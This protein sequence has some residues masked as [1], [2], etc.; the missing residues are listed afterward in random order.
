[1]KRICSV[2]LLIVI[3]VFSAPSAGF[4]ASVPSLDDAV[5]YHI[6]ENDYR[7]GDCVLTACNYMI[8][9]A[10]IMRKSHLWSTITN[11]KLRK[12][13]T[14][15]G[16]S[17]SVKNAYYFTHDGIR[18]T[19]GSGSLTGDNANEKKAVLAS[20]LNKYRYG[21]VVYGSNAASSGSHA[22][23]AVSMK[24]NTVYAADAAF[25]TG[26]EN[27][28]IQKWN[29]TIMKSISKCTK[30]WCI[31]EVSGGSDS[32]ESGNAKSTL[33]ISGIRAPEALKKGSGFSIKGI[34]ES[35]Y[36]LRTVTVMVK[37]KNG[38]TMISKQAKPEGWSYDLTRLDP[39]IKF[40]SLDNGTY[41]YIV[42]AEDAKK[43]KTLY[44][45]AFSVN[46]KAKSTLKIVSASVPGDK[47]EK[48]KAFS[49]KGIVKS[50]YRILSVKASITSSSDSSGKAL[51]K[52]SA[53]PESKS[54]NIN[55]FDSELKF[56]KLKKGKYVYKVSAKDDKKSKILIRKT[57]TVK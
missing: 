24:N 45:T 34:V 32:A 25:N 11:A 17:S 46:T 37:D 3:A 42:K 21:I 41:K 7:S 47:L 49:V 50:N 43:S 19:I 39:Y 1:M 10:A 6:S 36:P 23:L 8:R 56:S 12:S 31:T 53:E 38:K 48:G 29:N 35:N 20:L 55:K 13:A 51:Y 52:S 5:V 57:F 14:V 2:L 28:G 18:Y 40:G 4:A 16:N 33:R 15:G 26:E 54:Y 27:A 44:K 30:F 22:V 9:R